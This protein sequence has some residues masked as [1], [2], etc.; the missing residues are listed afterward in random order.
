MAP[1]SGKLTSYRLVD[2]P[3][4]KAPRVSVTQ[5]GAHSQAVGWDGAVTGT[6]F[7]MPGMP[8]MWSKCQAGV[9]GK[10]TLWGKISLL[11]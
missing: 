2:E 6:G 9:R 11:F 7:L 10:D 8:A 3:Q 4:I 1:A 5:P